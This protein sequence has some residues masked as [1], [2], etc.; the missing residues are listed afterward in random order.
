MACDCGAGA[1][2][3]LAWFLVAKAILAVHE[4][5]DSWLLIAHEGPGQARAHRYACCCTSLARH[6]MYV[7]L[8]SLCADCLPLVLGAPQPGSSE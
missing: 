6:S 7:R 8:Y 4:V 2:L 3:G 5:C 1:D